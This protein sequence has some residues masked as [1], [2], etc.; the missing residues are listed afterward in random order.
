MDD[1]F[2]GKPTY[3]SEKKSTLGEDVSPFLTTCAICGEKK[4]HRPKSPRSE[5]EDEIDLGFEGAE[6]SEIFLGILFFLDG[7]KY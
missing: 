3:F 4:N 7:K 1:F 6:V 5:L 2:G